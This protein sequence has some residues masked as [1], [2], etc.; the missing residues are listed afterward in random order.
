MTTA[1]ETWTDL[2]S[3]MR[4]LSALARVSSLLNW[5]QE[6]YMALQGADARGRQAA[7]MGVVRHERLTDPAL[8]DLLE[9]AA[10]E[11]LDESRAAMVRN[12]RRDRDRAVKVPAQLIRRLA[13]AQA[14]GSTAWRVARAEAD[15]ELFRPALEEVIAAK[16]EEAA[17]IAVDGERY[18]ALLDVYEPG[19]RVTT[20]EPLLGGLRD[21]LTALIARIGDAPP[22]PAPPFQGRI[23]ADADQWDLTMRMVADL[24]FDLTAGRQDRSAHPFTSTMALRDV[25][26]TT[27]IDERDPF[28]AIFSSLHEAGHGLY[29]QG[30]DPAYEDTPLAEAPSFGIHESQSRLWENVVGRSREFWR[31]YEPVMH[32]MFPAAMAGATA[33][34]LFREANRVQPSL[35]RVEADE[36]TYNLHILVR[37]QLELGVLREEL[38]AADLPAAWNELYQRLLGIRP[39]N[40]AVGVMQDIHWSQGDFGYFPSYTLGNLYSAMLWRSYAGGN[41]QAGEQIG[42]G[43]FA[44]L[45]E[46]LRER[47]HRR[48]AIEDADVIIGRATGAELSA[49]PFVDYLWAKYGDLYGLTR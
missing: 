4:D 48:G 17:A 8:G 43:E 26:L 15:F 33:E 42:R 1:T 37:F 29:E 31:H 46:W 24:G 36:V 21:E 3:R 5:D 39:Q 19:M 16:R 27:R 18:D 35:I 23:F 11:E 7:I 2:E 10:A 20:L 22:L 13:I 9:Q 28:D 40:D 49:Q 41:P 6:T 34:D 32:E 44:P 30:F 45:L 47:V 14:R 12:L 38:E 25:R